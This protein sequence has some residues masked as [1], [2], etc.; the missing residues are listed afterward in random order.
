MTSI[1]KDVD[2]FEPSYFAG[3]IVKQCSLFGKLEVPQKVNPGLS[4]DPAI[5]LLGYIPRKKCKHAFTQKS[6]L[7][8]SLFIIFNSQKVEKPNVKLMNG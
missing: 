5:P 2:T 3:E 4:Y 6:V 7:K 1:G 8:Y